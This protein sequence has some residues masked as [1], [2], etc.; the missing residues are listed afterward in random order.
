MCRPGGTT[1]VACRRRARWC[2]LTVALAMAGAAPAVFGQSGA[3]A[4]AAAND[5]R[6]DEARKECLAGRTQRGIDLLAELFTETRD[7]NYIFNQ[8]RCFQ[9]NSRPDEAIGRFQEYLRKAKDLP[10]A[11]RREVET[12]IAECEVT[13]ASQL[14][15]TP[16]EGT[17]GPVADTALRDRL[18]YTDSQRARRL[19]MAGIITA[20]A[21]VVG[22]G[23]GVVMGV[24]TRSLEGAFED[25]QR[26]M[27]TYFDRKAYND[28]QRA[29]VFQWVGY[30]VG[31][32]ALGTGAVF[33]YL[34]TRERQ[35]AAAGGVV[36]VPVAAAG[37]YGAGVAWRF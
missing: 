26:A 8:A 7:P 21:G 24:R 22:I 20:G 18:E 14:K 16:R 12:L 19:R 6:E 5:R 29:E 31:G 30:A 27:P 36:V 2:A 9:Q 15:A 23:F 35:A 3:G 10:A 32:V 34:G 11:E 13:K 33:Y 1:T 4:G 28:G 17:A 25:K 37:R